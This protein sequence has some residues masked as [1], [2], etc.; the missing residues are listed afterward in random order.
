[1]KPLFTLFFSSLLLVGCAM[2][3]PPAQPLAGADPAAM[4]YGD[5]TSVTLT[6][7]AWE[8]LGAGDYNAAIRYTEKCAE[9]YESEA[10]KMQASLSAL[11]TGEAI[12]NYWALNDVGTSYFIRGQALKE[13][14]KTKQAIAAYQVVT[15]ELF[16]AQAWDPNGWFW[17]PAEAAATQ[18]V[19]LT[20]DF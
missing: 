10:R 4:D 19:T 9:L 12:N 6:T 1:M 7:R 16:Y 11:P 13:Q 3:G 8:A 20:N 15:G 17:A 14:G 5:F 2:S 18:L